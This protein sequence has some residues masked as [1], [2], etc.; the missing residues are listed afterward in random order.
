MKTKPQ[1]LSVLRLKS[2]L[3]HNI[4][5]KRNID[6]SYKWKFYRIQN[7]ELLTELEEKQ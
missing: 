2:I 4:Q 3:T 1:L 6:E 7:L 5:T